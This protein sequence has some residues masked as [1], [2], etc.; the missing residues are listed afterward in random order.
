M[1]PS[2]LAVPA[3]LARKNSVADTKTSKFRE[4]FSPSPPKKKMTQSA[5]IIKFLNPKRLSLRSQ[6]EANLQFDASVVAVDGPSDTLAIPADRERRQSRS[7][8]SLQAEQDV[9]GKNKGANH[10]WDRAL[11]AHQE[12]KASLFLPKNRDLAVHACPFRERSG[13]VSLRRISV[14][15]LDAA[16]RADDGSSTRVSTLGPHA[17]TPGEERSE[18]LFTLVSRRSALVGRDDTSA[19]EEVATAFERQGDSK[20]IVGAWGRYPSHTRHDCTAS[21]GKADKVQ[22]RDFALEAAIKFASSRDDEDLIDPTERRP[23]TPLLPGERKKKKKKIGSGRIAK[24]NS[25]TFG[26]TLMKNYSKMF[27]SQ[28]TEFRRHGRG[29]RSSIASGGILEHPELELLPD[30]WAG[31]VHRDPDTQITGDE[32]PAPKQDTPSKVTRSRSNLRADDSMATLRPRRNSSALNFNVMLFRDGAVDSEHPHDRA[33]VWSVYYENCVDTYP[34][35]SMDTNRVPDNFNRPN[36]LSFDSRQ[37]SVH[38]RTMPTH[39]RKH[40]RNASQMSNGSRAKSFVSQSQGDSA[41]EER[42]LVSVRRST[43]D[44]ISKFKQQEATEHERILSFSLMD[45]GRSME[46]VAVL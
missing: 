12:E 20:E 21:A 37:V 40:T 28:S 31:D 16:S 41:C 39:L 35:L 36:R 5:S 9:L 25:M 22:P 29:H 4:E 33:R 17:E 24:S 45:S 32:Y 30:V 7:L 3:P 13:S 34:R 38:P 8:I 6:S 2:L 15:G 26:K 46:S 43:M 10:V 44:L 18:G 27:R 42:S 19:G 11:Q 1:E 23:S 14:E